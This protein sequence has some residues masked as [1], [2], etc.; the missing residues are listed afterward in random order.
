MN[1][2]MGRALGS[3]QHRVARQIKGGADEATG[4]W[5]LV[6]PTTGDSNGGGGV[7]GDGSICPKEA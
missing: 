4:G 6:L 3:F 5:Y 2:R 7:L 1:P